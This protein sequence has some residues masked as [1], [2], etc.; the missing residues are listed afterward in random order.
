[1][2]VYAEAFGVERTE[3]FNESYLTGYPEG[4][5]DMPIELPAQFQDKDWVKITIRCDFSAA[6]KYF[7]WNG[8]KLI[9]MVPKDMV[10]V[11]VKAPK[12][13]AT[14]TEYNVT[15]DVANYGLSVAT[16]YTVEL[17]ANGEKVAEKAGAE[18]AS[19][20]EGQVVFTQTMSPIATED[21]DYSA[22]VVQTGDANTANNGTAVVTVSPMQSNLPGATEL[23][24][25]DSENAVA[26]TWN[27]PD[28]TAVIPE[29]VTD[30]FEDANAFAAEYGDWVFVDLDE[31]NVGGF[32]DTDIPGITPGETKGSF[33]IWD[34]SQFGNK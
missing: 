33:W 29:P 1:M 26:L 7:I 19:Y 20:A 28:L 9:N 6:K 15:V 24:A 34:Q 14:G 17:Y 3:I 16:D 4:F 18:L 25:A 22:K 27:E 30:D 13:V 8:Y 21:I 11:D 12:K 2:T 5:Q 32:Q 31:E 23:T 10:A